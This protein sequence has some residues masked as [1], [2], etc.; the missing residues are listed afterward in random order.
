MGN[1]KNAKIKE[2]LAC[3]RWGVYILLM[4]VGGFY[5]AFTYNIRGGVFCNAQTG[6]FVLAAIA[7]GNMQ[8]SKALYYVIPITAYFAGAFLSETLGLSIKRFHLI[9]WDTLLVLFEIVAVIVLAFL[10]ENAPYQITQVTFNFICSMQYNTFRQAQNVPMA[11]TFC[12]NH[13][14]QAG[15]ALTRALRHH[16]SSFIKRMLCHFGMIGIFMIGAISATIL[17]RFFRG[18]ALLFTLIPLTIVA[19]D[20]LLADLTEEKDMLDRVPGGH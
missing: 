18:K 12:T 16:D 5:G 1:E 6:N 4:V 15:I 14:R 11:T 2:Y 7:L 20:L 9:R 8:W 19:V 13:L 17:C 3:E 10:P